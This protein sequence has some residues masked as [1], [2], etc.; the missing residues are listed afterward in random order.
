MYAIVD[1]E[2]TGSSAKGGKVTEVAVLIHD[3]E[4]VVD[5]YQSLVNPER[6]LP[7][8]ITS[9]TGITQAMV[10]EALPF[11]EI[12]TELYELLQG[13]I[14]VAHNVNF[15]Y[16]FLKNEFK[17]VGLTFAPLKLC[18]VRL[19]RKIFPELKSHALGSLCHHFGIDNFARHRAMGDARA[20]SKLLD[21]LL[22]HE[23]GEFEFFLKKNS[24]E[25][26]LPPH[27]NG[28]VFED[29]PEA[30]GV[31]YFLDSR[32]KTLYVG[33]ANQ[34]KK[35][36]RQHF[37]STEVVYKQNLKDKIYDIHYELCGDEMIA[38]LKEAHDIQKRFPP[39]NKAL[40]YPKPRFGIYHYQDGNG[41]PRLVIGK[42][43]KGMKPLAQFPSQD[44]ARSFLIQLAKEKQLD[45][46]HCGLPESMVRFYGYQVEELEQEAAGERLKKVVAAMITNE[47]SYLLLGAGRNPSEK[48]VAWVDK[49]SYMGYGFF[50]K[51]KDIRNQEFLQE[52]IIREDQSREIFAILSQ[53]RTK[54]ELIYLS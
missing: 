42:I 26:Y 47:A 14:F 9:L 49:G 39:Y 23:Q 13:H 3:G 45:P 10:D 31:Y 51:E 25:A 41:F 48:S 15:D 44:K 7:S 46:K 29:L 53:F 6:Y 11:R 1:I 16:G 33:K 52:I 21:L 12:A 36:V 19:S 18:S 40:K 34:I 43:Q 27:L 28:Q 30:T 5:E 4:R 50:S 20:T 38:F 37:S 54:R 22:A 17:Q 32:G 8:S 24:K 2:T 35:R